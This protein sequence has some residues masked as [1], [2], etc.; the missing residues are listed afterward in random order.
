MVLLVLPE[1]PSRVTFFADQIYL[2]RPQENLLYPIGVFGRDDHRE[3]LM[4]NQ[5][6]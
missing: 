6:T 3:F 2:A 4:P 1:S 5:S